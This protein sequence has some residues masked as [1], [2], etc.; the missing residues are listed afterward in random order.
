MDHNIN[1]TGKAI[2][3][4]KVLKGVQIWK[5]VQGCPF[6]RKQLDPRNCTWSKSVRNFVTQRT[7][8]A[9]LVREFFVF[10]F[11]PPLCNLLYFVLN[12][13]TLSMKKCFLFVCLFWGAY[14]FQE[15]LIIVFHIMGYPLGH[16]DLFPYSQGQVSESVSLVSQAFMY[17]CKMYMCRRGNRDKLQK[18]SQ[19]QQ[20]QKNV[21]GL[22][23]TLKARKFTPYGTFQHLNTTGGHLTT[24]L[25]PL[26]DPAC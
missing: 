7:A 2:C 8:Q 21:K 16:P 18:M 5:I 12:I 26:S 10:F 24:F 13:Y 17:E 1:K 14:F 11:Y 3:E 6:V 23:Q 25:V 15:T 19:E 4:I 20:Y 22:R 9:L